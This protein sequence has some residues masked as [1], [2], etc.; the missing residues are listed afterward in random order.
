MLGLSPMMLLRT[1]FMEEEDELLVDD[2]EIAG[3]DDELLFL[4]LEHLIHHLIL[5]IGLK[6]AY[7]SFYSKAEQWQTSFFKSE[8]NTQRWKESITN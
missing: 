3:E 5:L 8:G 2:M 7:V 6:R 1:P 4:I